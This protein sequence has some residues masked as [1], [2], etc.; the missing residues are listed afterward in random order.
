MLKHIHITEKL[1]KTLAVFHGK[2]VKFNRRA[3]ICIHSFVKALLYFQVDFRFC[4]YI[5]YP[6]SAK[7]KHSLLSLQK[8]GLY[9]R[10]FFI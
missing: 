8:F 2:E 5:P 6:I 1:E 10:P 4:F 9:F 3:F 7:I